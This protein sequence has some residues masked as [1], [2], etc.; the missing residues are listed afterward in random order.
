[1]RILKK[2]L[3]PYRVE[4]PVTDANMKIDKI[5][6]WLGEHLGAF[7]DQWNAV[8]GHDRT[9]FYFRDA[10]TATLFALKWT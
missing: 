1:M 9:D 8:Y 10:S 5:E 6:E 7:R 3:W 2:S 4:L